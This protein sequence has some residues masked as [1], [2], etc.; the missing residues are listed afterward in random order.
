MSISRHTKWALAV[1]GPQWYRSTQVTPGLA[2]SFQL[3]FCIYSLWGLHLQWISS[4]GLP[5]H[6][7]FLTYYW[8]AAYE[9]VLCMARD[10]PQISSPGF[11]THYLM[12]QEWNAGSALLITRLSWELPDGWPQTPTYISSSPWRRRPFS[13]PTLFSYSLSWC[14]SNSIRFKERSL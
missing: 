11:R 3:A 14:F 12:I 10:S 1:M 7:T 4:L 2:L 9:G 8:P 6:V 5:P 13:L